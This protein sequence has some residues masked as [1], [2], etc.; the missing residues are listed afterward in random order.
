MPLFYVVD[1]SGLPSAPN[2]VDRTDAREPCTNAVSRAP[3]ASLKATVSGCGFECFTGPVDGRD[4]AATARCY[5]GAR[6]FAC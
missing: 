6:R 5:L 2:A 1:P 4:G 3:A